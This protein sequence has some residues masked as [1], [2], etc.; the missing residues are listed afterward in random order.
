MIVSAKGIMRD[1]AGVEVM[2]ELE[3]V[4]QGTV[5]TMLARAII[6]RLNQ[7]AETLHLTPVRVDG[8]TATTETEW[9]PSHF[10]EAGKLTAL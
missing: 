10:D 4:I 8:F 1:A 3:T 2:V 9:R 7:A 6:E 5:D